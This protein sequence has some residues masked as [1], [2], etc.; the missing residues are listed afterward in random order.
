MNTGLLASA[1]S[2]N[3][4]ALKDVPGQAAT[5]AGIIKQRDEK[6]PERTGEHCWSCSA[7]KRFHFQAPH[8]FCPQ[9][10][11][12]SLAS[13]AQGMQPLPVQGAERA[14]PTG[15]GFREH[16]QGSACAEISAYPDTL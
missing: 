8:L 11:A 13:P 1:Q 12:L 4:A 16:L 14:L 6:A 3:A 2:L 9:C 10:S 7:E 5:F 15:R